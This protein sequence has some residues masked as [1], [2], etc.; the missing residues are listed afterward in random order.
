MNSPTDCDWF[1]LPRLFRCADSPE[2]KEPGFGSFSTDR[3]NEN[4]YEERERLKRER[5]FGWLE[6][7]QRSVASP[8]S[9]PPS[10]SSGRSEALPRMANQASLANRAGR[11]ARATPAPRR[12]AK[13]RCGGAISTSP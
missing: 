4:D 8:F 9:L 7:V 10:L 3:E 13:S 12:A 6:I 2:P 11:R 5:R 1:R